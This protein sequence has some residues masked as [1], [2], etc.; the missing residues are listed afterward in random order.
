M[1]SIKDG[2][3]FLSVVNTKLRDADMTL[4]DC[5]EDMDIDVEQM[6]AAMEKNGYV[7]NET[8]KQFVAKGK[9]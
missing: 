9:E 7:Y 8:T 3:I 4:E 2:A 5:C 1:F 6:I